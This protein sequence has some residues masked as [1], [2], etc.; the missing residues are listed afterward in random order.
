M[1]LVKPDYTKVSGGSVVNQ[2][3]TPNAFAEENLPALTA[4]LRVYFARGGQEMQINSVSRETL[5]DAME[6]PEKYANLV[7]RVSGFSAYFTRLD[8]C[9]QSD[10][11]ERTELAA[12]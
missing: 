10:I 8:K 5:K 11:L 6:H 9:V 2:K 3:F 7:V 4:L 1:S 12:V